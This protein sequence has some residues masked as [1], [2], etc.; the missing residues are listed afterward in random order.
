MIVALA[1]LV[2][3][4]AAG[5][6]LWVQPL[7]DPELANRKQLILWLVT[8]DLEAESPDL[9]ARLARRL[10]EEFHSGIDWDQCGGL[11]SNSQRARVWDNVL[12]LLKPWFLDKADTYA[13]LT[14]T[15]QEA[16]LDRQIETI[17]VWRGAESLRPDEIDSEAPRESLM[18]HVFS[19]I[20]TWKERAEPPQRERIERF[21]TALQKRWFARVMPKLPFGLGG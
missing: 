12:I 7:P 3:S 19:Q 21:Q 2:V 9:H 18:Q 6:A 4:V 11:L 15:E 1:A 10:D 8:R 5:W 16:Y 17:A 20:E 13:N 14:P